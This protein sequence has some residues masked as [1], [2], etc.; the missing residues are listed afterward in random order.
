MRKLVVL[1]MLLGVFSACS[2][3]G[4]GSS[5][6]GNQV[7]G[8]TTFSYSIE[9]EKETYAVGEEFVITATIDGDAV[10]SDGEP[11]RVSWGYRF[12]GCSLNGLPQTTATTLTYAAGT[13]STTAGDCTITI[14]ASPNF[15][16]S[17]NGV[18]QIVG[19]A[20]FTIVTE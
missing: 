17:V 20:T 6:D 15:T 8:I 11:V 5:S 9:P 19:D 14:S 3:S 12:S 16:R 4:G 18:D 2:S 13:A 1:L 10:D 7:S